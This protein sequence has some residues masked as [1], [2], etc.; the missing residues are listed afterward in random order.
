VKG[1]GY[2]S[3]EYGRRG[4]GRGKRKVFREDGGCNDI[5]IT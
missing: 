5:S 3:S 1:S 2:T 4:E